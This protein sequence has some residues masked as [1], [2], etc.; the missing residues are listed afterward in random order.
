MLDF[1]I[2]PYSV[3]DNEGAL[4]LERQCVQGKSLALRFR[5]PTFHGRSEVYEDYRIFC[6]K[7]N[8]SLVGIIA[9]ALKKVRLHGEP[10]TAAYIYDL[11]VHPGWRGRGVAKKLTSVLL[12]EIGSRAECIYTLIHGQNEKALGLACR[13]FG[14]E[15]VI[16]LSYA[17]IPVYKMLAADEL[18]EYRSPVRVHEAFLEANPGIEFGAPFGDWK[19]NGHVLSLALNREKSAVCSVW[20]NEDVLAEEVVR[21]PRSFRLMSAVSAPLRLFIKLPSIPK[22]GAVIRSWFLFDLYA[23]NRKS[24]SDLLASVNNFALA[25]GRTYLYL[26]L[27]KDDPQLEWIKR[28]CRRTFTFPYYFLA[29]GRTIPNPG[30]P[31]Y[32]DVRDL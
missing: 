15:T 22:P 14:A 4:A 32:I 6:A 18:S 7:N 12:E 3:A 19:L 20:S 13:N 16:P 27:R 24:L 25:N 2:H 26:L 23:E 28:A 31:L 30:D 9:G 21:I 5:R 1:N 10:I 8:G 11:R 17:A 29:K